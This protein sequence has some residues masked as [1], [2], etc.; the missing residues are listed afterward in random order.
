LVQR[1]H[2][3]AGAVPQSVEREPGRL[4]TTVA[5]LIAAL[6]VLQTL[7]GPWLLARGL[8]LAASPRVALAVALVAP[9]AFAMGLPFPLGLARLRVAAP[10]LVPWAWGVNGCAS[11][12]A[13]A[14]AGLLAMSFGSRSLILLGA[15]AYAVAAWA[16]RGIPCGDPEV[17]LTECP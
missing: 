12:V 7:A 14:L 3:V 9:L 8:E 4:M 13:A 2:N 17:G 1:W 15:F 5:A 16:Q 10:A 11:V 6:A